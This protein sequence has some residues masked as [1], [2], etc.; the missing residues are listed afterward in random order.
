M[1]ADENTSG[2][3]I[4]LRK[5][6]CKMVTRMW[7]LQAQRHSGLIWGGHVAPVHGLGRC[8]SQTKITIT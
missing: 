4:T 3:G 7:G 6:S 2:D 1:D 8:S 5:Y